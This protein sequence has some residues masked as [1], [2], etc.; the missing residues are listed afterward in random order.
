MAEPKEQIATAIVKARAELEAA[1]YELEKLPAV[2]HNSVG[3]AAHALNNFLMVTGGTVELLRSVLKEHRDPQVHM[4]LEGLEQA[5]GLMTH[6]VG[7]LM[8]ASRGDEAEL[9]YESVDLTVMARRFVDF[10][11]RLAD[12]KR[13]R[14]FCE[15][16]EDAP[17]AWTDRVAIAAVLDNLLS[18]ALKFSPPGARVW[19]RVSSHPDGVV[20]SVRD[21]GPGLGA[22]DQSKLFQA[23]AKLAPQ[24]TGGEASSGYGLAVARS[25]V[26]RLGGAIWCDSAPGEGAR[27]SF[28]V[29]RSGPQESS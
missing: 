20:V 12:Q 16:D 14:C 7:Q 25:F 19:C 1:L 18:N 9:R 6:T 4:W 3:L 24:P 13:I 15:A 23:G 2:S 29:P 10:Y 17:P 11:Q 21:E 28:R 5:N 8:N 27:F 22:E 26:E